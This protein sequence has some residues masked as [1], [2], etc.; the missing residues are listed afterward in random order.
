MAINLDIKTI[1]DHRGNLSVLERLPFDIKRVYYLHGIDPSSMR[2]GHAHK[3]LDRIMVCVTGSFSV[4]VRNGVS[5]KIYKLDNPTQGLRIFPMDWLDLSD[6]TEGS[7]CLVLASL[8]HDENDCI[9][10]MDEYND[11]LGRMMFET[12]SNFTLLG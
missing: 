3:E 1:I 4:R 12:K 2:G 5:D 8:E 7:V 10:D 11:K 6:F 9:R